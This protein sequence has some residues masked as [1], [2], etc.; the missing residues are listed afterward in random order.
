MNRS[1]CRLG[2]RRIRG[3]PKNRDKGA[4]WR[5]LANTI[6]RSVRDGDAALR[7][8]TLTTCRCDQVTSLLDEKTTL[9]Q[10]M[11]KLQDDLEE[12]QRDND[13][14]KFD[15]ER[16]NKE[17]RRSIEILLLTQSHVTSLVF[18]FHAVLPVFSGHLRLLAFYEFLALILVKFSVFAVLLQLTLEHPSK[19]SQFV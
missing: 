9:Q 7:Q 15:Y 11:K 2:S 17:V 1:R 8:I 14:L 18:L 10:Q 6:K 13:E 12:Q 19:L 16:T 5:Q 4:H 3:P